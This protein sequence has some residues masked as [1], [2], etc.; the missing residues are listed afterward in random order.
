[1]MPAEGWVP[2]ANTTAQSRTL[3]WRAK[4]L[5]LDLLSF[6]PDF[7]I[8]F[9]RLMT[10]AKKGGDRDVEG[11]EAMRTAMQE[12]ERKGY[13]AHVHARVDPPRPGG[14]RWKTETEVCDL[15]GI[16]GKP[17]GTAFWYPQDPETPETG[18]PEGW[19][20]FNDTGS[21]KTEAQQ[22]ELAKH[23]A[24]L[25]DTRGR[26]QAADDDHA[27]LDRLYS[28]AAALTADQLRRLLL[29]VEDKRPSKYKDF[30]RSALAQLRKDEPDVLKGPR[31]VPRTDLL[32]FQYALQHY[33]KSPNGLPPFV[34]R[35][36][37]EP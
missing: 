1:M 18:T 33:A 20:P 14:Q 27:R 5:L 15:P 9:D 4:G 13:L 37:K 26:Q 17:E 16:V 19:D 25:A 22:D 24:S 2:V 35:F 21:I 32:S 29:Q 30:R 6:P 11:R 23:G 31:A 28:A 12:L 34:T 3:S 8:T 36:P 7:V 10:M